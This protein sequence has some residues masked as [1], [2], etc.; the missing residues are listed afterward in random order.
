MIVSPQVV[1]DA[2]NLRLQTFVNGEMRQNSNTNDLLF[3][4]TDIISFISQG[5]TL[6]RGTIIMTGTPAGVAMGMK[7]KPIYLQ[8]GDVV[9]VQVEHLGRIANKIVF[10]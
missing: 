1:G 7:P 9:E 4:V 6:E 5:T 8:H 2:G 10:E 3:G